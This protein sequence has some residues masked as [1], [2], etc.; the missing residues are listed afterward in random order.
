MN[1]YAQQHLFSNAA[2]SD[3]IPSHECYNIFQDC[4]G[5]IWFGT[6]G[7]LCRYDGHTV[8]IYDDKKGFPEKSCYG[9]Y[10]SPDKTLWFIGS[11][12]RILYYTIQK[13]SLCEAAFS[14]ELNK[15]LQH[16]YTAQFY[17]IQSDGDSCL[18]ICNQSMS[19]SVNRYTN[20]IKE[21][22]SDS[23]SYSFR[24]TKG[25]LFPLKY[26]PTIDLRLL[27]GPKKPVIYP[28]KIRL[29]LIDKDTIKYEIKWH[30]KNTPQWR[31]NTTMNSKGEL[32]IGWDNQVIRI[33]PG[34]MPEVFYIPNS[35]LSVY[36]DK[37]DGLWVGTLK[38]GVL[39]YRNGELNSAVASLDGI[40]VTGICEDHEKG[41]WCSTLERGIYY[42]RDKRVVSYANLYG[43]NKTEGLLKPLDGKLFCHVDT[44]KVLK[45]GNS[46]IEEYPLDLKS[47]YSV[48][49]IISFNN[50]YLL[51]SSSCIVHTDKK[52][53]SKSYLKEISGSIIGATDLSLSPT[54]RVFAIQYGTLIELKK[55]EVKRLVNLR[56]GGGCLLSREK[57]VLIG[58]KDG[59][60]TFSLKDSRLEKISGLNAS[61]SDI[62]QTKPGN[63]YV[64]SKEKGLYTLKNFTLQAFAVNATKR[65]RVFDLCAD[66]AGYI[67]AATN[68]GLV[69]IKE[70]DPAVFYV[71]SVENGLP[72]NQVN[73]VSYVN[74]KIY[75]ATVEGL[76]AFDTK[77]NL[78]NT[79]APQLYLSHLYVNGKEKILCANMELPSNYV[80]LRFEFDVLS[81]KRN[82]SNRIV[83][84]L[85]RSGDKKTAELSSNESAINFNKLAPGSYTLSVQALNNDTLKSTP[86]KISFTIRPA[87][88]QITWFYLLCGV[89]LSGIVYLLVR[90]SI[91]RIKKK[92]E[93]K[94]AINKML[95]ES[96]LTALQAQMNPHFIF[97]AITSI[98]GYILKRDP[99]E[100]YDYLAKFSKLIRLVLNNSQ[101]NFLQLNQELEMLNLYIE[102]E[103]LRFD[104][105]FEFILNI[106]SS[107]DLFE[108][109]VPAMLVQPYVENAIWHGLLKMEK[110]SNGRLRI[111]IGRQEDVLKIIVED[112]GIGR[113]R[114]KLLVKQTYHHSMGMKLT[115][116]RLTMINRLRN[117]EGLNVNITDLYDEQQQAS[118]TRV[119]IF[120]PVNL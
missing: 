55:T 23:L 39:F 53:Q 104:K 63:F 64:A 5:Y 116:Q 120:I 31:C 102:L 56:S 21:I 73:K 112:N 11:G 32:F 7:G 98:Q 99:Q 9:I 43:N 95:A 17:L 77:E 67:W 93:A 109:Q 90:M 113:E 94:T 34:L 50:G 12:N 58:C 84:E 10:E 40:S 38:G 62:I 75:A 88:W 103:Q 81:F 29:C 79:S 47:G 30:N 49:D 1:L 46:E 54:G 70:K 105:S 71:Y 110:N 41:I 6:E 72:S 28:D 15:H 51:V 61:V 60:Y 119:E 92:E 97:N 86:L 76:C 118:G 74:G 82:G 101:E 107:I 66:E 45:I 22:N 80:N 27:P 26:K 36:T 96:Q 57:D 65:L 115:E 91:K 78:N 69:K 4:R 3:I 42:C 111:S 20:G 16:V 59:I 44:K 2:I 14:A 68:S 100:A 18:L 35:V 52:F 25:G 37:D 48:S 19:F 33:K 85:T 83:Y 106:D 13:D 87:F 8:K 117:Y 108:T 24:K 114:S 89:C